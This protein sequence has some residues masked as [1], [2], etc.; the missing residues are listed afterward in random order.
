MADPAQWIKHIESFVDSSG[1]TTQQ[2]A[3]LDAIS[4]LLKNGMLTIEAL[5]R[6]M[7]LYLTT[8]D[9]II[10]ARGILLLA[11]LLTRLAS[12]P[13]DDTTIQSLVGF[14]TERLA[15][16]KALR[17]ALVGC[18]ALMRRKSNAGMV[19]SSQARAVAES[20]LKNLQVQSLGQHDRKLCF[21]LLECLLDRYSNA[22]V[23]LGDNLV[24][25][26]CEAI[27]GEKDPQCL[28]LTFHIVE[29]LAQLFPDP[30]GPLASF[31]G[32]LFDI[33]GC[34]F[35]IHFTHSKGEDV[36]VKRDELSRSLMLAFA[37]TPL[38]EP[39]AIPLL[40]EKLS[41]SLPSA[42]VDSLKYLSYCIVKYEADR[43]AK[44]A[45]VLWASLKNAIFT[46][47][48]PVLSLESEPVDGM[49]FQENEIATEA[50]ILLQKVIL[51]NDALFLS[52]IS[53]DEDIN[54]TINSSAKFNRYDDIPTQNKQKLLAV[55]QILSVSAKASISSC[56]RVFENFF[57]RLMETLG[58]SVQNLSG[59]CNP[60]EDHVISERIDFGALYLCVEVLAACRLAVVGTEKLA[61]TTVS[62][63]DTWCCMLQNFCSSLTKAF[64]STLVTNIDECTDKAYIHVGVKGLQ[65]LATFPGSFF[66]IPKSI[67]E[68]I[69]M[70]FMSFITL[71]INK[72]LLWKLSLKALV[73]IGSFIDKFQESEKASSFKSIV[74]EK[75]VSLMSSDD[76]TMPLSLKLEVVSDI[77]MTGL[78]SMLRIVEGLEKAIFVHLSEVYVN[79]NLKSAELTVQLLECYSNK[80][81][82]WCQKIEGL[83]EV[84]FN[85]AVNIWDQIENSMA[86]SFWLQEKE[87]L[88][89]TTSA[90]K[91]AVG[92]CSEGRQSII[93]QKA[94]SVLSSSTS[95][96]LKDS[97]SGTTR[98]EQL[99][100]SVDSFSYR[101]EWITS[102]F[103]SVVIALHPQ[104][105]FPNVKVVLHVFM[106]ALV[107]G[108]VLAAQALGSMVNKLPLKTNVM[109]ISSDCS[110]EEAIDIVFNGNIW[111]S[112]DNGSLRRCGGMG[113]GSEIGLCSL[114]PSNGKSRLLQIHAIVGLAWMG[115][116][117]LMRGH[118]KI[119]DITVTFLTCLL[120]NDNAGTNQGQLK[121][122]NE[123]DMLSL[124]KS[125]A[126]AFHILMS[127]SEACL[128]RSFHAII[129]PLYKQRYFSTLMPILLSSIV[130]SDS[131]I[132][133]SMLYRA[134]AHVIS[135]TP[136]GAILCEAKK[137]IPIILD[138][139]SMLS[140]DFMNRSIIYNVLLV[141]SG[142][143]MEKNGQDAVIENVHNIIRCLIR[144]VSY[145]HMMLV[146]V[147]AIQCLVAM[148]ELPHARIYPM[149]T[150]VVRALLM[151][152][153]DPK[154]AV[155]QE[156]VRCRQ[157]WASIAS[158]SLHF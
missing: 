151:A 9:N 14:F 43:M 84:P 88:Y 39:F 97:T 86:Y 111:S 44:H 143:L 59:V 85:F 38:F 33:L 117:L 124:M 149:R 12:K 6:E 102:L 41:S 7:Q 148:S 77:S 57:I 140:E 32:D 40:L 144:L 67:F 2:A 94:F 74:V 35:P 62:V 25:G 21:E 87:L 120:S 136:P 113:D 103:A 61:M 114:G 56:N 137:L 1:S 133:R 83:E 13:L 3:S 36:G 99:D 82:P 76:F 134:F 4:I 142:I 108:H 51:Q 65:I 146:R 19:T 16:W 37:S 46:S 17:G 78:D 70:K 54:T 10:R 11:E 45:E 153:D 89:A 126:D 66:P 60:D 157:A 100:C 127:D 116:G 5:V 141:L 72:T 135:E 121:D 101:D 123:Q 69:L 158:R 130:K 18:L 73:E 23:A 128:N 109:D 68:N 125:A 15:D 27:D 112:F 64:S 80:V 93:I 106:T 92:S 156:A 131:S 28:M 98:I 24:Y 95:F 152:L 26:I 115:K 34:Y 63:C 119:K 139:L 79:G 105:H 8:T 122:S 30:L 53:G 75:I 154:R 58:L 132:K 145:P 29:G 52:L 91:L 50:L 138:A 48:M 20:Y 42:K 155:R 22:V 96:Q 47:I 110:L 147:T 90:M 81:L 104:T 118:E 129:R 55:G 150:Q 49:G 107:N 71:D 31:A